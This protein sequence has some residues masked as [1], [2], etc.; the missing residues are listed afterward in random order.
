MKK[1]KFSY[2]Q[3]REERPSSVQNYNTTNYIVD[4]YIVQPQEMNIIV[5][6]RHPEDDEEEGHAYPPISEERYFDLSQE[7]EEQD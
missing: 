3:G 5:A 1:I 2:R 7:F 6:G 4:K